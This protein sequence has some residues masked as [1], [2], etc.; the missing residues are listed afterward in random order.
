MAAARSSMHVLA[1]ALLLVVALGSAGA[2]SFGS[3]SLAN[4][5]FRSSLHKIVSIFYLLYYAYNCSQRITAMT[6]L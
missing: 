6:F 5:V 4:L 2:N 3:L 1:A